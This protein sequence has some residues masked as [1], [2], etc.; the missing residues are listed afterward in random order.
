[1]TQ[2]SICQMGLQ[3][4]IMLIYFRVT[5]VC[6]YRVSQKKSQ[7][8]VKVAIAFVCTTCKRQLLFELKQLITFVCTTAIDNI[9]STTPIVNFCLPYCNF[10][11]L[12]GTTTFVW[13]IATIT[14][15]ITLLQLVTFNA[16]W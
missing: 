15:N 5:F 11:R 7:N 12:Y 4:L 14:I 8:C 2:D 6:A 16:Q 9:L 13:T 3:P 1:M 10:Q